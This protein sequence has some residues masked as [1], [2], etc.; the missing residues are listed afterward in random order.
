MF[1]L[2]KNVEIIKLSIIFLW[3]SYVSKEYIECFLSG[4]ICMLW[5]VE[6]CK[7]PLASSRYFFLA[8][9]R[10]VR[11]HCCI[12]SGTWGW[13]SV[14]PRASGL[15][16]RLDFSSSSICLKDINNRLPQPQPAH[17]PPQ[18]P[19]VSW[20]STGLY[21]LNLSLETA[22]PPQPQPVPSTGFLNL[23][24]SLAITSDSAASYALGDSTHAPPGEP[25]PGTQHPS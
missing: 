21:I 14:V 6:I 11:C 19:P 13:G 10:E 24:L 4:D 9:W 25:V 18:P 17:R 2:C 7:S 5:S 15:G 22:R 8:L 16:H 12:C 20:D 1:M 23:S 3:T